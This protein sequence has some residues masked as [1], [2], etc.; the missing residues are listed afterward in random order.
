MNTSS[1]KLKLKVHNL[2]CAS[3]EVA[4]ERKFR[5]IPGVLNVR[6]SY[7][8]GLAQVLIASAPKPKLAE[9]ER[10]VKD[11]GYS[12]SYWGNKARSSPVLTRKLSKD[13]YLEIGAL[14]LLIVV[15]YL[16]LQRFDLLPAGL[17]VSQNMS[18]GFV[19]AIGIV[20]AFSSCLAV[21]GGLLLAFA[22]KY[23]E[24]HPQLAGFQKFK[25]TLY[26]NIGRLFSYTL[27][28]GA[29]GAL[30]SSFTLSSKGTGILS[31]IASGIMIL[32]GFQLLN[33]FPSLRRFQ[34][35]IPKAI[36]HRIHDLTGAAEESKFAPFALGASTF[37]LPCGFTQALQFY[38]LSTGS[39]LTG[40][41]TMLVFALGTL[42]S[43]LSLSAISSFAKGNFQKKFLRVAGVLVV[44]VGFW[45]INNGLTLAGIDVSLTAFNA[46]APSPAASAQLAPLAGGV[47]TA[48]MRVD[49]YSYSPSQFT[50]QAGL[51]VKWTIDG[52]N[53]A[54]CARVILASSLGVAKY[55]SPSGPTTVS[56]T[57]KEPGTYRF[58]CSMGMTT[59][60]AA[61]TVVPRT[62][63]V[64]SLADDQQ[65]KV[66]S[67][68]SG[69]STTPAP[70]ASQKLFME[71][72]YEKGFYPNRF[73]VKKGVPVEMAIDDKVELGGC[74]S[75]MVIPKYEVTLPFQ[76]GENHISF[77]PTETGTI[78]ATCSM[79]SKMAQFTVID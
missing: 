36:S 12:V 48:S 59:R 34:P 41:L 5:T 15:A 7:V 60:G 27:L 50:V 58:S 63:N 64:A 25:P 52:T 19:F 61:F 37:F 51:P 38:V 66:D 16:F 44:A 56:F 68:S 23:S 31:I 14:F 78:Y 32:L 57:P 39:A 22:A 79:G 62:A 65:A 20:A 18:Y 6:V 73:T 11:D 70:V 29:V 30:G 1:T 46:V 49:G 53:A 43:L 54:G 9:F 47:Q 17:A 10:A 33:V 77:T 45:N 2:H 72:S 75:V 4:V 42:P 67:P 24:R 3:C 69:A 55:L 76:L 74:M 13:D 8:T 28:G 40:A 21:T 35:K 71:I 26:F